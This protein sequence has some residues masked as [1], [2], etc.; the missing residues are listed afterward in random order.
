MLRNSYALR[1][2]Y[3]SLTVSIL[4]TLHVFGQNPTAASLRFYSPNNHIVQSNDTIFG[5]RDIP[6]EGVFCKNVKIDQAKIS[7]T[8]YLKSDSTN[9]TGVLIECVLVGDSASGFSRDYDSQ[10]ICNYRNGILDTT[11]RIFFWKKDYSSDLSK[12][13][14]NQIHYSVNS[15]NVGFIFSKN[16]FIHTK[17]EKF[18]LGDTLVSK[19]YHY[20]SESTGNSIIEYNYSIGNIRIDTSYYFI[21]DTLLYELITISQTDTYKSRKHHGNCATLVDI[22]SE[23]VIFLNRFN[24]PISEDKFLRKSKRHKSCSKGRISIPL[25]KQKL[26]QGYQVVFYINYRFSKRPEEKSIDTI[27]IRHEKWLKKQN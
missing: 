17:Y 19:Y 26:A 24:R 3:F 10:M 14:F 8:V 21:C 27:L 23:S 2:N 25:E 6:F 4:L 15:R 5:C 7:D 1:M 16:G 12:G 11:K 13:Y 22:G 9:F 20:Y 18:K